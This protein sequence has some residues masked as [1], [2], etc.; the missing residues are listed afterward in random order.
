M[1]SVNLKGSKWS[2]Q[3]RDSIILTYKNVCVKAILL[4]RD[5]KR[6]NKVQLWFTKMINH[7]NFFNAPFL[8]F[9]HFKWIIILVNF[10]LHQTTSSNSFLYFVLA[11]FLLT[12]KLFRVYLHRITVRF[13]WFTCV[14]WVFIEYRCFCTCILRFSR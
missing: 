3:S 7:F 4:W 9:Y 5:T 12:H 1:I 11:R 2:Y 6:Q 10:L 13:C 14:L 8:A